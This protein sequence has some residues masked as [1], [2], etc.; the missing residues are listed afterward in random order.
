MERKLY[1]SDEAIEKYG[2]LYF[3]GYDADDYVSIAR[4]DFVELE[5]GLLLLRDDMYNLYL[6]ANECDESFNDID[7]LKQKIILL[8]KC[9][10]FKMS[11]IC[12]LAGVPYQSFKNWKNNNYKGL[13][14][15][16]IET[17]LRVMSNIMN[18]WNNIVVNVN[19]TNEIIEQEDY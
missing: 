1:I 7:D 12:E 8:K 13:S 15:T 2:L 11:Y 18:D 9:I 16:R 17:L 3:D 5:D 19:E 6:S 14:D 4:D 10:Y